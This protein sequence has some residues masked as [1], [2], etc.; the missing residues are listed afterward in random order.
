M[1]NV[2]IYLNK[3]EYPTA[4]LPEK[5][6]E[7]DAGWDL[8]SVERVVIGP[9]KRSLVHTGIHLD[10]PNGWEAQIRPRSGHALKLGLTI[11]NS[12]GTIDAGYTGEVCVIAQNTSDIDIILE[13]GAK[14]A[15]MVFKEVPMVK[16]FELSEKPSN[17]NRGDSGF[18]SS[19]R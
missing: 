7:T 12:P 9:G 5:N 2:G 11:T 6:K 13:N 3:V 15:Q 8:F 19:G 10:L 1:L 4:R 18:G 16:V 14:I 17:E